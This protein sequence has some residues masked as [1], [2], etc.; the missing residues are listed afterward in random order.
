MV[1]HRTYGAGQPF[2][3]V[4]RYRF[5]AGSAHVRAAEVSYD[6][7]VR[8]EGI[9][10]RREERELLGSFLAARRS[11]VIAGHAGVGKTRLAREVVAD[12]QTAGLTTAWVTA[13]QSS[14]DIPFAALSPLLSADSLDAQSALTPASVLRALSSA[15]SAALP[16]VVVVDD[17]HLL[18]DTSATA[19]LQ[20]AA[21]GNAIVLLT[22]TLRSTAPDA[23]TALW[24]D[25]AAT[26]V[27]LQA[28]SRL[29]T[30]AL[31]TEL[32]GGACDTLTLER[33]WH[34]TEGN[35]LYAK[36]LLD[37]AKACGRL[38]RY[39]DR[40]KLDEGG[41]LT[42][43]LVELVEARIERLEPAVRRVLELVA[44][45]APVTLPVLEAVADLDAVAAAEES[46]LVEVIEDRSRTVARTTHPMHAE[47]VRSV[48]PGAR[49]RLL[50]RQLADAIEATGLRRRD[51]V[52]RFLNWRLA[53]GESAPIEL[54]VR[55]AWQA[56]G[57]DDMRLAERLARAAV[58]TDP[59]HDAARLALADAIYR[60]CRYRDALEVLAGSTAVDDRARTEVIIAR[61]KALWGLGRLDDAEI[62]LLDAGSTITDHRCLGWVQGFRATVRAALGF[63]AESI[64]LA[65][66]IADDP[67]YGAR[68]ATSSLGSLAMALAFSGQSGRAVEAVRKGTEPE[69]LRAA[70]SRT[71]LSWAAPAL[72]TAAWLSGDIAE[73]EA[74]ADAYRRAG[75]DARDTERVAGGSMA[76]GWAALMRGEVLTAISR[77]EDAIALAPRDD[78]IGIR[79]IA[80]I[81]LGWAH[82]WNRDVEG[83][84]M[85]LDEAERAAAS[86]ARWFDSCATI[87]RAWIA[88]T[89]G[90][91]R[92][93]RHLFDQVANDSEQR[94]LLPYGM[95]AL[96]AFRAPRPS[97]SRRGADHR[98]RR[99]GRWPAR[100]GRS[101]AHAR[102]RRRRSSQRSMR[103]ANSSYNSTCGSWPPNALP[104]PAACPRHARRRR[105]RRSRPRPM[106]LASPALRG[107][108]ANHTR[109]ITDDV[110]AHST[111][112]TN[113]TARS[114][115]THHSR[116]RRSTQRLRPHHRQPPGAHLQQTRCE[117]PTR[118]R[119]RT[120]P[121]ER[122]ILTGRTH[123]T[124]PQ[125][126]S[127]G[128]RPRASFHYPLPPRRRTSASWPE[129]G[130][131]QS[132]AA[133]RR[134]R[135][136]REG[137]P[138]I[139]RSRHLHKVPD[140]PTTG[141]VRTLTG[142]LPTSSSPTSRAADRPR[143][144]PRMKG[145]R[146]AASG[147][148]RSGSERGPFT[149][150]VATRRTCRDVR[151]ITRISADLR[152]QPQC[153]KHSRAHPGYRHRRPPHA[154]SRT[155]QRRR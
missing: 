92:E 98:A 68:A 151:K 33:I 97:Q 99:Q 95:L 36:E 88:A 149:H 108:E 120:W 59:T 66:P 111:G 41:E 47:V 20:L 60:Q 153:R 76:V 83:A 138:W 122:N 96:H 44:L 147:N 9:V 155:S 152:Y 119:P 75:L 4:T 39:R 32:L 123:D 74:L 106:R 38:S 27:E 150:P 45:A 86:G 70:E 7:R 53:A 115:R 105:R 124:S 137:W 40:W 121:H 37:A 139:L 128:V 8:R 142:T 58:A 93:A 16:D 29:E 34:T 63:P 144:S 10:G 42:G 125:S 113:R 56:T 3:S 17:G 135:G 14:R 62:I 25:G 30:D 154:R 134:D 85:A 136:V 1:T 18:D 104:P 21:T 117:Q 103:A 28:L 61:G 22:L 43:R 67:S 80:L 126:D 132:P 130:M 2:T 19:L 69:L 78:R 100:S 31:V 55:G 79:T 51:D 54:L 12:A 71:L 143:P 133:P 49:R 146:S 148:V 90:D 6:G 140:S 87:G 114:P 82:T 24:K 127:H 89:V 101:S 57:A 131:S 35:P 110:D 81:G 46:G 11:V 141:A 73:A 77:F 118:T 13:T 48:L 52:L 129:R 72:W 145:V 64:A 91:E 65:Q 94:G 107:S 109:A 26:R 116:H 5:S 23:V 102:P 84:I 112:A 50:C 15:R